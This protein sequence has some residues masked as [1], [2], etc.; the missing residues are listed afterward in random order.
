MIWGTAIGKRRQG[1]GMARSN[2]KMQRI[3]RA[4]FGPFR[5][6]W[7]FGGLFRG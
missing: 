5:P 6:L 7:L 4:V 1:R 2:E 3:G